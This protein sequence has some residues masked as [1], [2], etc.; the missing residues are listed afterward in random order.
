MFPAAQAVVRIRPDVS[1]SQHFSPAVLLSRR[2][3]IYAL[4]RIVRLSPQAQY[5]VVRKLDKSRFPLASPMPSFVLV[6]SLRENSLQG[7]LRRFQYPGAVYLSERS[8]GS[9]P[10]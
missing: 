4:V 6:Q 8:L 5:A 1:P 9:S 3:P 2:A 7:L 10:Q